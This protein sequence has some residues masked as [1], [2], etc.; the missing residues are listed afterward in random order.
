M[1]AFFVFDSVMQES[2]V[3]ELIFLFVPKYGEAPPPIRIKENC[4]KIIP[5]KMKSLVTGSDYVYL[6]QI[7]VFWNDEKKRIPHL[8]IKIK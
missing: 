4:D 1:T 2:K 6:V 3:S 5:Q 8:L 7:I